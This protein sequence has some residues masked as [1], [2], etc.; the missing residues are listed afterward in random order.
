MRVAIYARVS[1]AERC[2]KCHKKL[3]D[4]SGKCPACGEVFNPEGQDTENQLAELRV[5]AER[6]DWA[7]T[8][9]YVDHATGKNGDRDQFKAM[10]ADA[11]RRK[12]DVVLVWALDRLTREGVAGTFAYIRQLLDHGVQFASYTEAHF[13]TTG[14]AGE[15]MIAIAAWIA[16]QE[17]NR[18]SDRTKAGLATARRK[19]KAL[20]RPRVQC[21]PL[22]LRRLQSD[23]LSIRQIAEKTGLKSATVHRA[24]RAGATV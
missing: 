2:P 9:E 10:F 5:F 8:A 15:L 21:E 14:P 20:G 16:E 11:T 4:K 22:Y 1:K 12:F 19:G 7:V 17:R 13:R 23:G 3:P 18:I 24:M 6:S